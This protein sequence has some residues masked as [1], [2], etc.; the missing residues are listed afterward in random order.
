MRFCTVIVGA[1][2]FK[3]KHMLVRGINNG[4]NPCRI[5]ETTHLAPVFGKVPMHEG[6]HPVNAAAPYLQFSKRYR[7]C[8]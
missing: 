6:S 8:V 7:P 3:V 2:S 5:V 1:F 4:R